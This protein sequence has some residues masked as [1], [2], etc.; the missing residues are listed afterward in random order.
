[1]RKSLWIALFA[2]ALTLPFTVMAYASG[3][4]KTDSVT[5][6]SGGTCTQFTFYY[7]WVVP[8]GML[9]RWELVSTSTRVYEDPRY[10]KEK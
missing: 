5:S 1:M 3:D 2:L 6:C 8:S 7:V 4:T 10:R 9:G